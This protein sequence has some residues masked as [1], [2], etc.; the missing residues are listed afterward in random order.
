M[1]RLLLAVMTML[2]VNI[3]WAAGET[4]AAQGEAVRGEVREA[5]DVDAYTYLRLKTKEGEL[6]AAVNKAPVRKGAQVTV[7]NAMVMRDFKS[8]ALN[9]TFDKVIFAESVRVVK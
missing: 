8:K 7:E 4:P 1:T 6:W 9:R 3:A 5:K 2:L